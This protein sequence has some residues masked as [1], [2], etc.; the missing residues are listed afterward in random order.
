MAF[1]LRA[2]EGVGVT[3]FNG[4][5]ARRRVLVTG[6]TGFKGSW[7][8]LWLQALGA[9]VVG[10]ALVPD[11]QPS[12]WAA[13]QLDGVSEH[14]VD[15]LDAK[16]VQAVVQQYQPEIIFHLAAQSLVRRGYREPAATFATNVM[17]LVHLLEAVREC[18]SVRVVINATTDKVY[19]EQAASPGYR[20]ADPLGGHDPY[21][22]SKACA[23]LVSDCWRKSFFVSSLSTPV[24]LATVRAGNVI[25]GGDWA[26][27]RLVPDLVRAAIH[28]K[29]LV[30]RNPDA[31]R[32]WQHVLEPLAGYL[33]LAQLM[34]NDASLARAWNFGPDDDA[35]VSVRV[36]T[37]RLARHWSALRIQADTRVQPH[38]AAALR[39]DASAARS[40][41]GWQSVW[42][43]DETLEYTARWY[44]DFHDHGQ[45]NSQHDLDAYTATAQRLG[46]EWAQ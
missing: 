15:L 20:E 36:I 18:S 31:I 5:Y 34:W 38:E 41:L 16:A 35:A 2:L 17:G 45:V 14:L 7:L 37:E 1:R 40:C 25:G 12:H 22:S 8:A 19:A 26:E 42:E 27:D 30:V 21:S 28:G 4:F 3:V 9:Q 11:T 32:P 33:R 43:L 46:L 6:Y 13:L 10:L 29:A 39:L 44:C 24:S 23:E